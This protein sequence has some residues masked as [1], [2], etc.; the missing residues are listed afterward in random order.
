MPPYVR[1]LVGEGLFNATQVAALLQ[2]CL[3]SNTRLF[4]AAVGGVSRGK[5]FVTVTTVRDASTVIFP[6]YNL[7]PERLDDEQRT[8]LG[9]LAPSYRRFERSTQGHEPLLWEV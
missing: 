9:R 3:G 8:I 7:P 4:D 1:C 2:E 6:S 5:F